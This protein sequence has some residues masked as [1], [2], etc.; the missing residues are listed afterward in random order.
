MEIF[1]LAIETLFFTLPLIIIKEIKDKVLIAI[2]YVSVLISSI[3]SDLTLNHSI[4]KYFLLAF[5]MHLSL[6]IVC[7]KVRFYDLFI[8]I[9][10]MILKTIIEYICY[11]LIYN[12][13]DYNIFV[14]AME[15]ISILIVFLLAKYF[16]KFY[17]NTNK[18]WKG[19]HKFYFRYILL[20]LLNSYIIFLI[21][22]L[23][24]IRGGA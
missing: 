11:L 21:Y 16:K 24:L 15:I 18:K 7:D 19:R 5:L 9:M 2:F 6:R 22:N 13:V 17:K 20:I 8:I 1:I 10:E 4:F 12:F 23:I 3:V 14:V